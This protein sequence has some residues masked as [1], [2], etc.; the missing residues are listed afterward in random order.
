MPFA[1]FS[2][3]TLQFLAELSQSNDKAWFE[4]HREQ[5]QRAV[6]EPAKALVL[7]LGE[8]LRELDPKL[9]AIPR[10]RGSIK[11]MERRRR[12]PN[13]TRPPYKDSLDSWFWS[14]QRRAWDN[15]GFYLRLTAT[16]LTLAAGM[17][18]F[19]KQTLPRYRE[20]VLDDQ[21]GS[22]L[23]TIVRELR[24]DGYPVLGE[25]YKRTPRGVPAN[26][27]RAALLQHGGLFSTHDGDHPPELCGAG[28]VDFCV[29]HFARLAPLHAWLV[30][31]HG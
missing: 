29:T 12:F 19:Q 30:S 25:K 1:G 3:D 6:L 14:G 11:A 20:S 21:R 24:A 2:P 17:I 5:C 13:S 4:A 26:H 7:A 8:R 10:E 15:S 16:R 31:L 28:L 9:Q 27:P 18:E 22:A 23:A